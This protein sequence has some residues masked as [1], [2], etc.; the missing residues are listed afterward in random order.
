[1]SREKIALSPSLVTSQPITPSESGQ[2]YSPPATIFGPSP[3]QEINAAE[4]PSPNSA[5]ATMLLLEKSSR[6]KQSAQSST[7]R[8]RTSASG[9]ERAIAAAR[10]KPIAPP[11]HPK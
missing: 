6:R 11:A 2:A 5:V 3:A 8:K 10:A 9:R 7:T 4:A 1:M